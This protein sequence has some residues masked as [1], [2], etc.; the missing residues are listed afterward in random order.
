M[1][2]S[3]SFL[4]LVSVVFVLGVRRELHIRSIRWC[5]D[6]LC[7]QDLHTRQENDDLGERCVGYGTGAR[8][9]ASLR[10]TEP[11]SE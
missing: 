10:I 1:L 2:S 7:L 4:A 6:L 5:S 9:L 11:D 8:A 3:Q